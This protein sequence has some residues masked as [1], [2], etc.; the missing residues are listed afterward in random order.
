[1]ENKS[2][3]KFNQPLDPENNPEDRKHIEILEALFAGLN[4]AAIDMLEM[5]RSKK[6]KN[7]DAAMLTAATRFSANLWGTTMMLSGVPQEE[8][9]E[10][11]IELVTAFLEDAYKNKGREWA[12]FAKSRTSH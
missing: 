12:E 5:L 2:K 6:T 9:T 7:G 11:H 4:T 1:M 10:A 8:A 3:L